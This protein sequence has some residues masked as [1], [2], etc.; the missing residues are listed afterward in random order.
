M[1][2]LNHTAC[3]IALTIETTKCDVELIQ[4]GS[5]GSVNF[6]R[7]NG[8]ERKKTFG[9]GSNGNSGNNNRGQSNN[10]NNNTKS[11]GGQHHKSSGQQ[12]GIKCFSCGR[13]GHKSNSCQ[14]KF[15]GKANNLDK[16]AP[17]LKH[18]KDENF[19]DCNCNFKRQYLVFE[20]FS[21]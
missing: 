9:K 12:R 19:D 14:G 21:S 10:N 3:D 18:F 11:F 7:H 17:N 4:N 6:V 16:N 20:F 5:G 15:N 8:N 13:L 1:E 2:I